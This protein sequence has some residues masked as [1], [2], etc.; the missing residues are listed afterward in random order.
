MKGNNK[1]GDDTIIKAVKARIYPNKA[2]K[3]FLDKCFAARRKYWNWMVDRQLENWNT[4]KERKEQWLAEGKPEN[5]F[6][7]LDIAQADK[8]FRKLRRGEDDEFNWISETPSRLIGDVYK[9]MNVSFREGFKKRKQKG[10]WKSKRDFA[11]RPNKGFPRFA[12]FIDNNYFACE[13]SQMKWDWEK[14]RFKLPNYDGQIKFK[15]HFPKPEGELKT[16][17]FTRTTTNKYYVFIP[18]DTGIP[19]PE[20]EKFDDSSTIGMDVGIKNYVTFSDPTK[21]ENPTFLKKFNLEFKDDKLSPY[22][23]DPRLTR[24]KKIRQRRLSKKVFRSKNYD[25]QRLACAKI[26]EKI[27]DKRNDFTHELSK[28]MINMPFSAFAIEDLDI[29][30]MKLKKEPIKGKDGAYKQN[31]QAQKRRLNKQINDVA[32]GAL[33]SRLEYKSNFEGKNLIKA[34]RYDP[35]SKMCKCGYVNRDL[36]LSQ[37]AWECPECGGKNDRDKLAAENV[38][39]F[40][41]K[42]E[43]KNEK[44]K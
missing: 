29:N 6:P 17:V 1:K 20:K 16:C 2:D 4:R 11:K 18:V 44:K 42:N 19:I 33:F 14:S 38:K 40:A 10:F 27:A 39:K 7:L 36:K 37:R 5:E 23:T 31:G 30:Q 25:K 26:D 24:R 43:R 32:W 22:K 21:I 13:A 8:D 3:H 15:Q 34:D 41:L 12:R 28:A 9:R 35:T